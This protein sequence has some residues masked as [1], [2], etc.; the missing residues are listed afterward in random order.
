MA[1]RASFVQQKLNATLYVKLQL[2]L[3]A[4]DC[5]AAIRR[6][7]TELAHY[8]TTSTSANNVLLHA[9]QYANNITAFVSWNRAEDASQFHVD[10]TTKLAARQH[11]C[12]SHAIVKYV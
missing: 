6:G 2:V 3:Q 1:A 12:A 10:S 4:G 11:V 8:V 5:R 7:I 9:V